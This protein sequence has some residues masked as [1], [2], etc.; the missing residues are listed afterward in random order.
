MINDDMELVRVY[1]TRQSEQAFATLVARYLNLVYSAAIR[2]VR[3]PHLAEEVTQA[4][5]IIL[6]RK[7]STLGA[8]TIIPSW[9]HRTAGFAAADV[10]KSRRRRAQRE[11]EAHMQSLL[12]EPENDTWPQIAPLLDAA[13]AALNEKDRHA[14]VLRFFQD[15]SLHEIAAAL[16]ASEDAA[17]MRVNRALEKLRHFFLKRGIASTTETILRAISA[18]S[19]QAA[20]A[21]LAKSITA[22]A[23]AK[24]TAASASTLTV[25]KGALKLMAWTK[26]K[27][28]L[29]T[30]AFVLLAIGGGTALYEARR[31]PPTTAALAGA[32]GPADLRVKWMVGKKYALRVELNQ[33]AKTKSHNQWQ[34]PEQGKWVQD[35][36]I[37]G[38][39]ELPDGG[40]QLELEFVSETVDISKG[41]YSLL[42]FDS[43]QSP[44]QDSH[45]PWSI[46]GATIG[47]RI[48]YFT[49]A[50]GKVQ[51]V[52]GMDELTSH[53]A[54]VGTPEQQ[55]IFKKMFGG[56]TLKDYVSIGDILPNRTVNVGESWSIKK[57]IAEAIGI[58]AVNAKFTFKNWEQRGGR[59][60]ARLAENGEVSSKSVATASGTAIK[61]EKGKFSGDIWFDP[62]RGLA[63]ENNETEDLTLKVT[64]RT[65]TQT[66]QT[67]NNSRSTLVEV[68]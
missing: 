28:A 49:D 44:T 24:G 45:T 8:D 42:S 16:G 68:P 60:C 6:A 17:K 56:D 58:L 62:E 66:L 38:L 64:S 59:K 41:G 2:Q 57:E 1:A 53:I 33:S 3:D 36:T 29:I 39:K 54:A 37:S 31:N 13:I 12:D 19:V 23:I 10:L 18:N 61:I 9:L 5:F 15:K 48:E 30:S 43:A 55:A 21:V 4:V 40:R 25:V 46:L 67:Q 51:N 34:P 27:T 11:Q 50:D 47:A 63:V 35:F 7:A 20:P 26:T 65:Q 22:I 14:I 52:A 32:D